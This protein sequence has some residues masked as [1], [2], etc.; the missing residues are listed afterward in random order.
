MNGSTV[1]ERST[2]AILQWK[3]VKMALFKQQLEEI[4]KYYEGIME[5]YSRILSH[6]PEGSL[7]WQENHGKD[8]FLHYHE[9]EGAMKRK[10]ITGD[11]DIQKQLAR[12]EFARKSLEVIGPNVDVLRQAVNSVV[13]FDPQQILQSMGK[14][15]GRL[16]RDYFFDWV[17]LSAKLHLADETKARIE[18]HREWGNAPYIQSDYKP[19]QKKHSTSRGLMVRS[20][21]EVLIIEALYNYYD[22][23]H[24]YEQEQ[25]IGDL[26]I[27]PDVTFEGADMDLFYLEHLGMMDNPVYA[28]NNFRK[29]VRYYDAGLIPG[30][31]LLLSFDRNGS[32]DMRI[33]RAMI[34]NEIIPRL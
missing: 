33:I 32:I 2:V 26:I 31:N 1:M 22:I 24:R 20:K 18:R 19:Y 30:Q 3:G 9:Q 25:R 27:A 13:P 12:K 7:F 6:S 16:P 17:D 10:V 4:L 14:A 34:E 5:S 11:S 8:Q 28:H 15:Y 23:P 21:S 29:L